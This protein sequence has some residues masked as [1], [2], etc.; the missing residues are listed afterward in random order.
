MTLS[1]HD[2]LLATL[3]KE[4]HENH[5]PFGY[6]KDYMVAIIIIIFLLVAAFIAGILFGH[7][8]SH[9]VWRG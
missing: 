2:R 7:Y 3:R 5:S 4:K 8:F 6:D 1:K 9:L